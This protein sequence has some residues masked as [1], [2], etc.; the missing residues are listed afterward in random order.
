MSAHLNT[1]SLANSGFLNPLS[2][3]GKVVLAT[4]APLLLTVVVAVYL[5][6]LIANLG[7]YVD[8]VVKAEIDLP[9]GFSLG[10]R[11]GRCR[12]GT[13]HQLRAQLDVSPL[14]VVVHHD[15]SGAAVPLFVLGSNLLG[16][17]LRNISDRHVA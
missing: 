8:E 12:L 7:G 4:T 10:S 11:R 13:A 3:V 9:V 17:A 14:R 6:I 16:D 15:I 2:Q 5:T 1:D